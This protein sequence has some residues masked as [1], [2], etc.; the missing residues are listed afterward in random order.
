MPKYTWIEKQ[1]NSNRGSYRNAETERDS[2][3]LA[4]DH[5]Y[6]QSEPEQ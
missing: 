6:E 4:D 5:P 2:A 1:G 3:L